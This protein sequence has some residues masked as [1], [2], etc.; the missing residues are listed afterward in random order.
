LAVLILDKYVVVRYA[1]GEQGYLV[2]RILLEQA[3]VNAQMLRDGVA[4]YFQPDGSELVE[5]DPAALPGM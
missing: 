2:G 3:D 5:S 4:W 1:I